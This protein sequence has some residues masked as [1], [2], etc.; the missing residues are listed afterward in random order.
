MCIR[1]RSKGAPLGKGEVV[2]VLA[3]MISVGAAPSSTHPVIAVRRFALKLLVAGP[4]PQCAIDVYKRQ[5]IASGKTVKRRR[6]KTVIGAG[7]EVSA[8]VHATPGATAS[9]F[10]GRSANRTL[11]IT[12]LMTTSVKLLWTP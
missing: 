7:C 8:L 11:P 2:F 9:R 3:A 1:D 5:V 6:E 10:A 4:P 12:M